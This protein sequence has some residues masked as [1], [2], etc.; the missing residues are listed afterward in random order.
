MNTFLGL[1]Q[2]FFTLLCELFTANAGTT[3]KVF[4]TGGVKVG[5]AGRPSGRKHRQEIPSKKSGM[6]SRL[7]QR[8]DMRL[9]RP[10]QT[11]EGIAALQ[12]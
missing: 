3:H 7:H 8:R 9:N 6:I 1:V 4:P 5:S 2:I 12:H 11:L 10:S